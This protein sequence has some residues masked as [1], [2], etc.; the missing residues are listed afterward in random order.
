MRHG[1]SC[2]SLC[3]LTALAACSPPSQAALDRAHAPPPP[4]PRGI[5]ASA[6]PA[7]TSFYP[8]RCKID[9]PDT[10]CKRDTQ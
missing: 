10:I 1:F 9:G 4:G 3:A 7:D 8:L 2:V 6:P 5:L